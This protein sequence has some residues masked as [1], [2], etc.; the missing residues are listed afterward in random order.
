MFTKKHCPALRLLLLTTSFSLLD[1][2]S[3]GTEMVNILEVSRYMYMKVW[4]I[5]QAF[6]VIFYKVMTFIDNIDQN[7][8]CWSQLVM[9]WFL[10]LIAKVHGICRHLHLFN[11]FL[12]S[13]LTVQNLVWAWKVNQI[14]SALISTTSVSFIHFRNE[15]LN[16][17]LSYWNRWVV[18]GF[19]KMLPGCSSPW[20]WRKV[21][22]LHG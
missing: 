11:K 15:R 21:S 3:W 8:Q 14:P 10:E 6:L 13:A 2:T 20:S 17:S 22:M 5:D 18:Y 19:G 9:K 1:F 4:Q 7:E 16:V 12:Q